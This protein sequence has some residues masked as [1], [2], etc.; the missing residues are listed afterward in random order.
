MRILLLTLVILSGNT[1]ANTVEEPTWELIEQIDAVELRR[2][3]ATIEARTP[4]NSSRES[5][6]G[7]RR[8]AGYIFGGN[9]SGKEIAMTAPVGET[10]VPENPV[11]SFTMP[12]EYSMNDLPAPQ[13]GSV[14]L[15]TVPERTIAAISFSGWATAG[16]V[17]RNKE[18]LLATLEAE[19]I[20]VI[21]APTLNQY[22]PPWTPPFLRRNEVVVEV[23]LERAEK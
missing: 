16:K 22:N 18:A 20:E 21:G 5:S 4:L 11:M 7:F 1:M 2:Y 14:S 13:D 8:L 17:R 3:G 23:G 9:D 6:G 15:H 10:L 12:S 19:G